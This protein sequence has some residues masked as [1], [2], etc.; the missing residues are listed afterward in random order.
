MRQN[1]LSM[2][3]IFLTLTLLTFGS[4]WAQKDC[5]YVSN[6]TDSIGVYKA[7]PSY[8]VHERNFGD[9]Q[10]TVFFSLINADGLPSL[11]VQL[12]QK[13]KDFIPARC[14]DKNAR[15]I[16]QLAD[17]KIVSLFALDSESCAESIRNGMEGGFNNRLLTGYFL[18]VKESMVA[19]RNSPVQI[20]R[21]KYSSETV[22]YVLKNELVSEI[23]QKTYQPDTYFVNYLKCID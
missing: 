7:T 15:V 8:I 10:A 5:Q 2:K 20:L 6:V 13:S 18:F 19:L 17:G 22:D 21:I 9:A 23:D 11:K 1:R 12:I 4:V 3:S 14:F 16:L